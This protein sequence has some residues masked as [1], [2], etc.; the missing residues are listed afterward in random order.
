MDPIQTQDGHGTPMVT[1]Q[2]DSAAFE[3]S[4]LRPFEH[5]AYEVDTPIRPVAELLQLDEAG[6]GT[7]PELWQPETYES[8]AGATPSSEPFG[9]ETFDEPLTAPESSFEADTAE[10]EL[11]EAEEFIHHADSQQLAEEEEEPGEAFGASDEAFDSGMQQEGF[12][13]P[14]SPTGLLGETGGSITDRISGALRQGFWSLAVQ[15]MVASGVR[16]E[17]LLTSRIFHARHPELA[18]R[19]IRK[20]ERQLAAE[21]L[22]IRDKM[23]RPLIGGSRSRTRRTRDLR[24]AWS[25]YLNA[26]DKMVTTRILGWNTPV[27]PET[28]A[29]WKALEQALVASGYRAHRAWVF[30]PRTIAGTSAPSLHAY[31]LAIDI[32][33]SKPTCN[34]NRRTPD[35]RLVRFAQAATKDERCKDVAENRTDT[36]FTEDQVRAVEAIQTVDGHQVF[37]WG[38]R[39]STTKDTMHFQINV[40]PQEL[41]RGIRAESVR[42]NASP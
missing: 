34:I 22:S 2:L 19:A 20:D 31:G 7:E 25:Q 14:E 18:G 13:G 39:W 3:E 12:A 5:W 36:I 26:K 10:D 38:G 9:A 30:V 42:K 41:A 15:L 21:W 8:G 4:E 32:D 27:N 17:N 33:H 40:T 6:F 24:S 23:I 1:E 29:A 35:K 11:F 16:D 37:T 28:V